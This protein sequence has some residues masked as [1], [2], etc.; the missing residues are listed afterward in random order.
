MPI[1]SK[2]TRPAMA[3]RFYLYS[4]RSGTHTSLVISRMRLWSALHR[5]FVLKAILKCGGN[6]RDKQRMGL[7]R[8]RFVLR[9]KLAAN[10]PWMNRAWQ[11]YHF[12]KLAVR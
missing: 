9:M 12:D 5:S 7:Q 6:K 4:I 1:S 11:F 8:L 3:L 2:C 10:E